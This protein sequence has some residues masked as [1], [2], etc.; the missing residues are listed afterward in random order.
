MT[1]AEKFDRIFC[2]DYRKESLIEKLALMKVKPEWIANADKYKN[3]IEKA[4]D[5]KFDPEKMA[6]YNKEFFDFEKYEKE[7]LKTINM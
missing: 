2:N 1:N 4:C 6:D 5:I 7:L 3:K